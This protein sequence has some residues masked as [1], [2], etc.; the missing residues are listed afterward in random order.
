MEGKI[1]DFS[2]KLLVYYWVL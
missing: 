1:A 2:C